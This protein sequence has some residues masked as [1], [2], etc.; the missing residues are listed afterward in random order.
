MFAYVFE[1]RG[2]FG[3]VHEAADRDLVSFDDGT[4]VVATAPGAPVRFL[5]VSGRPIREPI[6]WRGPI[7]MNTE[8]ELRVAFD[9]IENDTFVKRPPTGR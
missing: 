6:A 5:L 7:V 9:E 3:H 2:V 4:L 1:G 8:D